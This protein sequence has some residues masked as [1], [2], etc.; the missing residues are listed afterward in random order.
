[1][2]FVKSLTFEKKTRPALLVFCTRQVLLVEECGSGNEGAFI[3]P[4]VEF[5]HTFFAV[6]EEMGTGVVH[7]EGCEEQFFKRIVDR[8]PADCLNDTGGQLTRKTVNPF[9][10]RL[11]R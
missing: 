10:P 2:S 8:F 6:A 9:R 4:A 7:A 11:A 5:H 3:R 1:M